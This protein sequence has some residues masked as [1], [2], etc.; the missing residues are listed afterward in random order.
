MVNNQKTCTHYYCKNILFLIFLISSAFLSFS[1]TGCGNDNNHVPK[2]DLIYTSSNL[3]GHSV[4]AE[5]NPG[6]STSCICSDDDVDIASFENYGEVTSNVLE[7]NTFVN[8]IGYKKFEETFPNGNPIK[9]GSYKYMGEFMLPVNPYPDPNQ[10]ENPQSVHMM[11][12]LWDGRNH[13]YQSDKNTLEGSI[14]WDLNPWDTNNYGKIKVYTTTDHLE[15]FDTNIVIIPDTEWHTFELVV[16]LCN[17]KYISITIDGEAKD[18]STI[19]L[20]QVFQPS[21]GDDVSLI[22]TTESMAAWP[23]MD[24]SDIYTWTTRFRDLKL[25][26]LN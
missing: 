4:V 7:T 20:A 9:L 18:L 19:D 16:D 2:Y 14:Y 25:Y 10:K 17:K 26:C 12:Q 5:C 22:I 3:S 11:I 15:L 23:Q 21:W 6:G 24:C 13:L 1:I 8:A